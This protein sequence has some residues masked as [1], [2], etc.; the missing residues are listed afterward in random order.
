M[1]WE[2]GETI[3][4]PGPGNERAVVRWTAPSNGAFA[5]QSRFYSK[6]SGATDVSV[7]L[8]GTP[9]YAAN[10]DYD[11]SESRYED[12]L[13]LAAGDTVDFTV[14]YGTDGNYYGDSTGIAV[15]I[16]RTDCGNGALDLGEECDD[17]N[18][19]N[20][21]GCDA[22]CTRDRLRQRR[23]HRGR[24]VRRRQPHC[25]RRLRRQ[26]PHRG[27]VDLRPAGPTVPA[28]VR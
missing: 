16:A 1:F 6:D 4:H 18:L 15:T 11:G 25:G 24:A 27:R 12:R 2:P 17:G 9:V 26:L 23:R 3:F 5:V 22:N 19:V 28:G 21:D 14:G 20:G 13:V 8:N 10:L 7:L